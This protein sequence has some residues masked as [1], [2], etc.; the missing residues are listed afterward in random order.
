MADFRD[1][2]T[3]R[4]RRAY[5]PGVPGKP[6]KRGSP[7]RRVANKHDAVACRLAVAMT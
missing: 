2:A 7:E 1:S 5:D 3:R 6:R 4:Q